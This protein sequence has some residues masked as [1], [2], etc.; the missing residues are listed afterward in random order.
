M[1]RYQL[2]ETYDAFDELAEEADDAMIKIEAETL[3][4]TLKQYK[5]L[6]SLVLWYD[7]LFQVNFVSKELQGETVDL[8]TAM[9]SFNNLMIWIRKLRVDGFVQILV[10]AK[11]LA[12]DMEVVAIFPANCKRQYDESTEDFI[13]GNAEDDYR[14]NCFNRIVD[15]AIQSLQPTFEQLKSN[16][17]QLGLLISFK[18]LQH[19]DIQRFAES[20]GHALTSSTDQSADVGEN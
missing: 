8:S 20:L 7:V 14:I 13:P 15:I 10:T 9:N 19:D 11:D 17:N 6:V 16:H 5:F 3:Y 2:P 18:R 12:E 1:Y 4:E